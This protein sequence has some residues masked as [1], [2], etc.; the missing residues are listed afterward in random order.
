MQL[1]KSKLNLIEVTK[2]KITLTQDKCIPHGTYDSCVQL[3]GFKGLHKNSLL[4]RPL[5]LDAE[6]SLALPRT[7]DP[8]THVHCGD[9]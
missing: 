5:C 2:T 9:P 1:K 4:I 3:G 7:L 6:S 8:M